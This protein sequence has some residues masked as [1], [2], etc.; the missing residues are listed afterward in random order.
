MFNRKPVVAVVIPSYGVYPQIVA[1]I[2]NAAKNLRDNGV[3]PLFIIAHNKNL[4]KEMIK[5]IKGTKEKVKFLPVKGEG[6]GNSMI[7]GFDAG[8]RADAITMLPDDFDFEAKKIYATVKPV[9][10]KRFEFVNSSWP[11]ENTKYA[12]SFP[13]PQYLN[14]MSVSRLVSLANPNLHPNEMK[15]M[16]ALQ[17]A[18]HEGKLL[19]TYTGL[20]TLNGKNWKKVRK[21]MKTLF[22]ENAREIDVWAFEPALM[23]ASLQAGIHVGSVPAERIYEHEQPT[24]ETI[25][26]MQEKRALQY[27]V[28]TKII[29]TFLEK[30][31]QT[32]KVELFEEEVAR[33]RERIMKATHKPNPEAWE[34]LE[35]MRKSPEFRKRF[36]AIRK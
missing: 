20:L 4:P 15:L 19:Q 32:H 29:R 2:R 11:Y 10:E 12:G 28:A 26:A 25:Q 3:R 16:P 31:K 9:L 22:K 23:L 36:P 14:E 1:C 33:T 21:A 35:R 24:E 5:A 17:Q 27:D 7:A 34:R 18:E 6:L 8:K 30:T 13:K